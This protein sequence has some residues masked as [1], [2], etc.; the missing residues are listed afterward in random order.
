[1]SL[2]RDIRI[3][4]AQNLSIPSEARYA[5]VQFLNE[6]DMELDREGYEPGAAVKDA[7][8]KFESALLDIT[9]VVSTTNEEDI[10]A[11]DTD[12]VDIDDIDL[13]DP[14]TEED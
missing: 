9:E 12:F 7:L 13:I 14:M 4:T 3:V 1:M 11:D 6:L 5:F 2:I 8:K 10:F